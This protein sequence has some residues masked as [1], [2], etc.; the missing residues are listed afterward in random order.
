MNKKRIIVSVLTV[1]SII[2]IGVRVINNSIEMKNNNTYTTIKGDVSAFGDT[3]LT[4]K[5]DALFKE[6]TT[7]ISKDGIK[8]YVEYRNIVAEL[9]NKRPSE[10]FI[11]ENK[12]FFK[13]LNKNLFLNGSNKILETFDDNS[14]FYMENSSTYSKVNDLEIKGVLQDKDKNIKDFNM[15]LNIEEL[16]FI[17]YFITKFVKRDNDTIIIGLELGG[18]TRDH[19]DTIN[20]FA[21]IKL[22]INTLEYDISIE[23]K[24]HKD[25]IQGPVLADNK[26][27]YYF[28]IRENKENKKEII[29]VIKGDI[30]NINKLEVVNKIEVA[31]YSMNNTENLNKELAFIEENHDET[32]NLFKY[33]IQDN[34]FKKYKNLKFNILNTKGKESYISDIVV[35]KDKLILTNAVKDNIDFL[36]KLVEIVDLNNNKSLYTGKFNNHPQL[37]EI[38]SMKK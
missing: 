24:D 17:H 9:T 19:E 34:S 31:N 23:E 28:N 14:I 2:G 29:E 12:K 38:I 3:K 32:I 13:R 11:N 6:Y 18:S 8:K 33:N 10:D 26:N 21:I 25:M 36:D 4:F 37:V 22:D 5:G 15:N 27:F 1:A 7:E 16:D 35:E 30:N 20:K